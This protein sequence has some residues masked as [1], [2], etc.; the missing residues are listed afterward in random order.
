MELH[1]DPFVLRPWRED[2]EDAVYVACQDPETL[3]WLPA[4][5]R[6]YTR[7]DARAFVTDA[8]GLGPHQYAITE[9]GNVVGSIGLSVGKYEAGYIGYWCIPEVRR[10]GITTRATQRVCRY[11]FDDLRLERLALTTDVEN[12]ASQR[13][14][15]KV[16]FRREGVLRSHVRHPEGPRRDS[17]LFSMLP[18]ELRQLSQ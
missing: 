16:G 4:L 6:P 1:D 17:V 7:G 15:E 11:A 2:D 9:Q 5:P 8:L 12:H 10:R 3:R 14:A 18:G 13:V